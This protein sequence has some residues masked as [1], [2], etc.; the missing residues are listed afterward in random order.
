MFTDAVE[1]TGILLSL[2]K[3]GFRLKLEPF[4]CAASLGCGT[5]PGKQDCS[6]LPAR[7]PASF[8]QSLCFSKAVVIFDEE[9]PE[10]QN[11]TIQQRQYLH[12][13]VF[14]QLDS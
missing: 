10:T 12:L 1:Q 13:A 11:E 6:L 9:N 5:V 2:L 7:P 4:T 8:A 14:A 3:R